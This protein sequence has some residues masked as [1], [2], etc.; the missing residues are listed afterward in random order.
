[1]ATQSVSTTASGTDAKWASAIFTVRTRPC[2]RARDR[3]VVD[4]V[5]ERDV[6][7]RQR[8]EGVEPE[9]APHPRVPAPDGAL[10]RVA[11]DQLRLVLGGQDRLD[12][13]RE[14]DLSAREAVLGDQAIEREQSEPSSRRAL[15]EQPRDRAQERDRD[16]IRAGDPKRARG[17]R[18]VELGLLREQALRPFGP[19]AQRGQE[20]ERT[21]GRIEPVAPAHGERIAEELPGPAQRVAHRRLSDVE[22]ARSPRRAALLEHDGEHVEKVEVHL[23]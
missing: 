2:R 11:I 21:R 5:E 22:P 6:H 9:L 23:G 18:G 14:I 20:R 15:A 16:S 12:A 19:S 4:D 3:P 7:V 1:M 17:A 13:D 10:H 8:R